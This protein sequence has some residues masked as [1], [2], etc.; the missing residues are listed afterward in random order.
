MAERARRLKPELTGWLNP[1]F[2]YQARQALDVVANDSAKRLQQEFRGALENTCHNGA[3]EG[4]A[5][6]L[7]IHNRFAPPNKHPATYHATLR[8]HGEFKNSLNEALAAPV[9]QCLVPVWP[10]TFRRPLLVQMGMDAK[11]QFETLMSVLQ[12]SS[13]PA[14]RQE[15][16]SHCNMTLQEVHGT[17]DEIQKGIKKLIN[18]EQRELSRTLVPKIQDILRP[19]Y[20]EAAI[21]RGRGSTKIQKSRRH[22]PADDVQ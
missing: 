8:H 2:S 19:V 3:A 11:G 14:L 15:C 7:T 13:P 12:R 4:N 6:A 5:R 10:K 18:R 20:N 22:T 16:G 9:I 1:G 17:I 21:I